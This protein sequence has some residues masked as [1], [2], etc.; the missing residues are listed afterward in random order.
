MIEARAGVDNSWVFAAGQMLNEESGDLQPFSLEVSYYHG[1]DG[2]ESWSEG[3]QATDTRVSS[4]P[5]G[6]TRIQLEI[7]RDPAATRPIELNLVVREDNPNP[8]YLFLTLIFISILPFFAWIMKSA[9][10]RARWE[11]SDYPKHTD[12]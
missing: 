7:E 6:P 12:E 10:E 11:N 2:G 5:G 1:V 8:L 9:H 3:G 4:M